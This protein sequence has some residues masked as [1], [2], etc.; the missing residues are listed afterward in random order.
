LIG[1]VAAHLR[2]VHRL[3]LAWVEVCQNLLQLVDRHAVLAV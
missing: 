1:E 2:H 3:N